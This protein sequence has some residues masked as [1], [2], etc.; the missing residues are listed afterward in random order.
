MRHLHRLR[1]SH[2]CQKWHAKHHDSPRAG[3]RT[4]HL[5]TGDGPKD[6]HDA[7]GHAVA[8]SY[9]VSDKLQTHTASTVACSAGAIESARLLLNSA[10]PD[11][12]HGLGNDFDQ[13]G[14]HLQGHTYTAAFG[15]MP[16]PGLRRPSPGVSIATTHS[17]HHNPDIIGGGLA[18]DPL[19]SPLFI[20][21]MLPPASRDVGHRRQQYVR[22]NYR[23][24]IHVQGPTQDI[25]NP[26]ARVMTTRKSA[27][28][29]N[30]GR[31]TPPAQP[32]PKHLHPADFLPSCRRMAHRIRQQAARELSATTPT[33]R[34][35]HQ[36]PEPAAW[37][38]IQKSASPPLGPSPC[39]R[40]I[41][42]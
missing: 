37:E 5:V 29:G 4:L 35:Q 32:T 30:P 8:V 23:R 25:P 16:D 34:R 7:R 20:K 3:D 31:Q 10:T 11:H 24:T 12:P 22:E 28:G 42:M 9:F 18:N 27:T 33:S 17:N 19:S 21:C 13:V 1:L 41:S 40:K 36:V 2:R 14:R 15:L 6:S 39:L 38:M 26:D